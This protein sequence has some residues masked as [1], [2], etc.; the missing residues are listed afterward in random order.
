[1]QSAKHFRVV[2]SKNS[3]VPFTG[4]PLTNR[5]STNILLPPLRPKGVISIFHLS[6]NDLLGGV[7]IG[8]QAGVRQP[9]LSAAGITEHFLDITDYRCWK[10]QVAKCCHYGTDYHNETSVYCICNDSNDSNTN[11]F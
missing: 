2:I 10:W 6:S 7:A 11:G 1:M 5:P 4:L 3:V 9:S 8:I